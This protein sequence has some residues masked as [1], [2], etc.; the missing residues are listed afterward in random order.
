MR[1]ICLFITLCFALGAFAQRVTEQQAL[2]K[3]QDF[4]KGKTF[5]KTNKARSV[6]G[7]S[8]NN[9]FNN[10]YIFNVENDEGFVIVSG[11]DRTK[12]ILGYSD[13]GHLDYAKMPCNLKSWLSYYEEAHESTKKTIKKQKESKYI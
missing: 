1:K 7:K 6:M 4:L 5:S 10:F 2:Q 12:D 11:D 3:A 8:Q 13:R 9:P